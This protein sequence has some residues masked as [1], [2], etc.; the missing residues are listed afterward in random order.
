MAA[1]G[2]PLRQAPHCGVHPYSSRVADPPR[3][4][5]EELA[6]PLRPW[7][8]VWDRSPP[9]RFVVA[10]SLIPGQPSDP[11]DTWSVEHRRVED[12]EG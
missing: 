9:R 3:P 11:L 8:H 6:A 1:A 2:V 10:G 12:I 7:G 4:A 5:R